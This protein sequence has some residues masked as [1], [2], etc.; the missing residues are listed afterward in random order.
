MITAYEYSA[1]V[2]QGLLGDYFISEAEEKSNEYKIQSLLIECLRVI[3]C[4]MV[5][6]LDCNKYKLVHI[7]PEYVNSTKRVL[8]VS[9]FDTI[10][11]SMGPTNVCNTQESIYQTIDISY[12]DKL[13]LSLRVFDLNYSWFFIKESLLSIL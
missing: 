6:V 4:S 11:M 12:K 7:F 10:S 5:E 2:Q 13:K 8:L 3:S 1:D 9:K